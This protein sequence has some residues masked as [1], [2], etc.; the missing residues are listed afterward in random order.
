MVRSALLLTLLVSIFIISACQVIGV[1]SGDSE[2]MKSRLV[3]FAAASLSETFIE[4]GQGFESEH[5]DVRVVFNFAGSQQLAHQL[6]QG[7]PADVFASA[8]QRQMQ[9][10]VQAGL[11]DAAAVEVFAH[12]SLVVLYP[13]DNPGDIHDLTDLVNPGLKLVLADQS[14]PVGQY[15][16][17]FLENASHPER[18]GSTYSQAV[19]GN[20]VS[21]EENVRAVLSKI[22]LGE[23]DG[24]VTY[25]SDFLSA[26]AI[27]GLQL[28]R[29]DIPPEMNVLTSYYVA[30]LTHGDQGELSRKFLAYLLSH[31]G[32]EI[33]ASHGLMMTSSS[34]IGAGR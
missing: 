9:A 21:Y 17:Q 18:L 6:S 32:Q 26:D 16:L 3:V 11:V 20:V 19:L 27:N 33:L 5:S 4:I 10:V 30:P 7:A 22:H 23:V 31:T 24:G 34:K 13:G 12:N 2:V 1:W 25:A 28:G 8:N 14:V 29:L 15:S